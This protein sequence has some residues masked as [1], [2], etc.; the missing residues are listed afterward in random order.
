MVGDA[1]AVAPRERAN[2]AAAIPSTVRRGWRPT[3]FVLWG[4]ATYLVATFG[5]LL[6]SLRR[7][8]GH[9]V[10]VLDDPAIHLSV[11]RNL[12]EHGT[13]GVVP[14][15]F[16]SASSSPVWTVLL[17]GWLRVVPGPGSIAP[18]ALNVAFALGVIALFGWAQTTLRP[19]IRRPLDVLATVTLV[20]VVLFL[21]GLTFTGM[22]HTLHIL[23]VVAAVVLFHRQSTGLPVPGPAWLPYALLALATLSRF[24]TG[25][26]AVGIAAAMLLTG[27][28]Q[29]WPPTATRW[30]RPVAVLAAPAV[31]FTAF[32]AF[33][34]A[35]GQGL[36]P[37]SVLAKGSRPSAGSSLLGDAFG[38]FGTD[39]LVALFVGVAVVALVVLGRRGHAWSFPAVVVVVTVP[40]HMVFAEVGWF[41]RYQAYLIALGVYLVLCLLP[42]LPPTR[43]RTAPLLVC[44]LAL[45]AGPKPELLVQAD[46]GFYD[47]YEQRYQLARFLAEHYDGEPVATGEL[48]YV[49]LFHRGP[50]TDIFGLGD[51][52]V[53]QEWQRAG[54]LPESDYWADL[55][56]R[57][58][59][60][61]VAVYPL[62]L[63]RQV[64]PTW[65]PVGSIGVDREVMTAFDRV[66][67]IY[68]T[69]PEAVE[70]LVRSLTQFQ[71]DVPPGTVLHV[72]ELAELRAD[73]LME[74]AAA[75]GGP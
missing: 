65:V 57:R 53:L 45:F 16:E 62:N 43:A 71:D 30:R 44:L 2:V 40:L 34:R 7:T 31:A 72:N 6:H 35:M 9:L 36:L 59:V 11:A 70:R 24:E 4:G 25:F 22:E 17:A 37:N 23:L 18:L 49:S 19:S 26:V 48:G 27:A 55:V 64:P 51:N 38:R 3:G 47:T 15:H 20:T 1:T 33:N 32:A 13:W 66:I 75:A 61:V 63:F 14:G 50:I 46:V 10:Y 42:E 73:Q 52:E 68:A 12:A 69:R 56:E 41:E 21:P 54:E 74:E 8:E 39:S 58:R 5:L 60:D 29:M 28:G 67:D